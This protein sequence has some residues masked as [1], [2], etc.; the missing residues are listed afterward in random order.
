MTP[1]DAYYTTGI[2]TRGAS[3]LADSNDEGYASLVNMTP[4]Q[5][6]QNAR[7]GELFPVYLVVGEETYLRDRVVRAIREA[8]LAGGVP[9]LNDDQ[10]DASEGGASA[11]LSLART[12]PMMARRRLVVVRGVERWEPKGDKRGNRKAEDAKKHSDPFELI[13]DYAQ[14]PSPDS[15]LLLV[16]GKIDRRRRIV[17]RAKK[18]GWLV[19]C[20][21]LSRRELPQWIR[22]FARE[23]GG[24]MG[25]EVADLIA[26]LTGPELGPVVDAVERLVLYA[27]ARE[28]TEDD[29]AQCLVKLRPTEVWALTDAVGRR[30]LGA[31]LGALHAVFE[32]RDAGRLVGVLAWSARQL[33]KF[34]AALKRG[35]PPDE[36]ARQA[37]APP[38]KARDLADQ[39]KRTSRESLEGWLQVLAR[40][41]LGLKGGTKRPPRAVF[42]HAIVQTCAAGRGGKARPRPRG[43]A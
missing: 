20:D 1:R 31:A 4:E 28:V 2:S 6:M 33:L 25:V 35:A 26:E 30:D 37:G 16:G 38:F 7:A 17:A 19:P 14:A 41:D 42:E 15:V 13:A 36:A 21:P 11:V 29:V 3:P 5:A 27:G 34:E 24:S 9:G 39:V 23:Q 32:P 40:V 43:Q 22:G 10:L 8:T 12:M 18:E